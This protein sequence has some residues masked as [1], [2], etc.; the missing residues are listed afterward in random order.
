MKARSVGLGASGAENHGV[1]ELQVEGIA[2][3]TIGD[4]S[5]SDG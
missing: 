5:F 3:D 4:S 1:H 2:A